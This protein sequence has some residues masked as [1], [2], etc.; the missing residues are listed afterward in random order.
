[1]ISALRLIFKRCIIYRKTSRNTDY[2]NFDANVL[3]IFRSFSRYWSCKCTALEMAYWTEWSVLMRLR[4]NRLGF[5]IHLNLSCVQVPTPHSI[6]SL[7][8]SLLFPS[9]LYCALL[10]LLYTL[11]SSTS[12]Y[13]GGN[14]EERF[15]IEAVFGHWFTLLLWTQL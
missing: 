3:Y 1:M 15:E 12:L 13:F 11:C 9:F 4:Y 2:F 10:F 7:Y 14:G 8:G 5:L 6:S